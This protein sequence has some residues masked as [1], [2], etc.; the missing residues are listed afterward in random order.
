MAHLISV[1]PAGEAWTVKAD[2]LANEMMFDTGRQA[3]LSAR[4]LA[5]RLASAG[6]A[7]ELRIHLRDGS[8]AGR[9][10]WPPETPALR[11]E[12]EPS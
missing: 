12:L 6:K 4:R 3:E 11:R 1:E 10:I 7:A 5:E 8:L 2:H 9:F